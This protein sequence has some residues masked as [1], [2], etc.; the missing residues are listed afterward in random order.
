MVWAQEM[1]L[2]Y[3]WTLEKLLHDWTLEKLLYGW[4]LEKLP[5]HG[6]SKLPA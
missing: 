4:A 3:G 5:I 2:L 6:D 1:L